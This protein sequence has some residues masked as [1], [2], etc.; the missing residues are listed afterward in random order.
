MSKELKI[1][2]VLDKHLSP[3]EIDGASVPIEIST[4]T[5]R[6]NEDTTFQKDLVVEGDLSVLGSQTSITLTDNVQIL[7]SGATGF[8]SMSALGFSVLANGYS[9]EDG[10]FAD[11]DASIT[12]HSSSG[13]DSFIQLFDTT[14]LL[15]AIGKD[16]SDS[17]KLKF[18]YA[19]AI[20]A[21]T[22]LELDGD[23]N[24]KQSGSL[25]LAEKASAEADTAGYGQLWVKNETPTELYFT[26]DA[27]DDIQLTDGTSAAGGGGGSSTAYWH[28]MV[29]GYRT[30]NISTSTYYTFYR[31]W[32]ELWGNADSNPSSISDTD[33]YSSFFIAPR[34]GT[35][36][37]MKVQGWANDTGATDPFKFY[38]YKA[39][40]DNN[41]DSV[42]L[43][44]MM[45]SG[46]ITPPAA[47]KTF[48]HTVDFSSDNTFAEDDS[49]F[50]WLKKD[51][52]SGNQDLFF[53][54]NVNGEYS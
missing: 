3:I 21:A 22:K 6:F 25:S 28:Q 1:S 42:S 11:N 35:I 46:A 12:L 32:F 27:G 53:N 18:D 50:I 37:N 15:W 30:N 24:T 20:G 29:S 23:G 54:I 2:N 19:A 41:S 33:V 10:D 26:T 4:E 16:G 52:N 51:S 14:S 49:L 8:V 47:S 34:A 7:S 48:S 45:N 5:V 31:M 38:F 44:S 36:T 40:L 9:G 43:T 39:A 13:Y 17:N